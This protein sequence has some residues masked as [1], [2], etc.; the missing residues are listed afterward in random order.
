MIT[1]KETV[2]SSVKNTDYTSNI[3]G[4]SGTIL[5]GIII[6]HYDN[7][8]TPKICSNNVSKITPNGVST[9]LGNVESTPFNRRFSYQIA[10]DQS[11]NIYTANLYSGDITK[12][13][14]V[15][16]ASTLVLIR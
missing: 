2:V 1:G 13:I 5:L 4:I 7:I 9:I 6:D 10:I 14:Q 15:G 3:L 12:I 16:V 11:G 8:Y